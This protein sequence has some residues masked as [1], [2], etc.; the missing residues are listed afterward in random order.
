MQS[1]HNRAV[2]DDEQTSVHT[3]VGILSALV[4]SGMRKSITVDQCQMFNAIFFNPL[5][6]AIEMQS[7]S[8]GV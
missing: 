4:R 7:Y 1:Q 6:D 2:L 3:Y 8:T 5:V